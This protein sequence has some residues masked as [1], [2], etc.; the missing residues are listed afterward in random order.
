MN[1]KDIPKKRLFLELFLPFLAFIILDLTTTYYGVCIKGGIELNPFGTFLAEK[2]GFLFLI[3]YSIGIYALIIAWIT[4][5]LKKFSDNELWKI[6]WIIIWCM[7]AFNYA[8]T[9]MYNFS[10]LIY[11]ETR[12]EI[13]DRQELYPITEEQLKQIH[14]EFEPVRKDFCRLI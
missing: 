2:F 8:K 7:I 3:P 12:V 1:I 5:T 4:L 14:E 10:T 13:V 9:I 11:A 6:I